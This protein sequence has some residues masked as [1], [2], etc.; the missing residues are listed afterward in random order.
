MTSQEIIDILGLKPLPEEGGYYVETYRSDELLAQGLLPS[1]Y[2]GSRN[3]HTAIYYLLTPD[4]VSA[5]HKVLSDEV[6]HFYL[7]DPVEMLQL[8]P[9]G[10]HKVF[11][12]GSD[13]LSGQK[14]QVLA[15][16]GVWQGCRLISGGDFALMGT[17]VSPG[18]EFS[19]YEHGVREDLVR[20]YP[21]CAPLITALTPNP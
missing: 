4:T 18:F 3:I 21:Q 6:F 5:M 11:T 9:D 15:P 19:D 2:S 10:S 12:I 16:R 14:P 8:F 1:R 7:G 17:T 13:L 20:A